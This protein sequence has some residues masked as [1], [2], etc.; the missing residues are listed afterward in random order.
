VKKIKMVTS[1]NLLQR[2]EDQAILLN[3]FDIEDSARL[4]VDAYRDTIDWHDGDDEFV[5]K[6][7]LQN[8][9]AGK[10]GTFLSSASFGIKGKDGKPISQIVCALIDEEPTILFVYTAKSYKHQGLAES[11]IRQS[12]FELHKLGYSHVF[13]YVTAGNPAEQ[14]YKR[15]GFVASHEVV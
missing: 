11:L 8:T 2:F 1:T 4:M 12:A 3:I 13:L 10:Y 6:Q 15:L 7:E 5:A 9:I 14:L